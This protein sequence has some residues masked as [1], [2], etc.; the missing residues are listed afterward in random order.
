MHPGVR[1]N[2]ETD[3]LPCNMCDHMK[4]WLIIAVI[5]NLS[6]CEIKDLKRFAEVLSSNPVQAWLVSQLLDLLCLHIF[7]QRSN[8]QF[9]IYSLSFF[10][11]YVYI[12]KS[13]RYQLSV[14]RALH[15][16]RRGHGFESRLG[17]DFIIQTLISQLLTLCITAMINHVFVSFSALQIYY[18]SYIHLQMP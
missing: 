11:I 17:L 13:Q 3:K 9:F 1:E 2:T 12:T 6:S 10:I 18:L 8:I 16:Y 15:W 4:T 7:L 14:G 5:H